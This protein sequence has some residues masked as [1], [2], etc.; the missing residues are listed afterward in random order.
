MLGVVL[1]GPRLALRALD[2]LH[3]LAIAAQRLPEVEERLTERM[4]GVEARLDLALERAGTL[5]RLDVRAGEALE[6]AR[7]FEQSMP[8]FDRALDSIDRLAAAAVLLQQAVGTLQDA[9]ARVSRLADLLP[10]GPRLRG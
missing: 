5:D 8:D 10:G 2:D 7:S 1:L 9:G 6:L 4:G 3:A